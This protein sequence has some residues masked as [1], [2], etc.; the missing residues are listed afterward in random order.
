MKKIKVNLDKKLA[1]SYEICIGRN[2]LDR[3]GLIMA[4]NNWASRYVLIADANVAALHGERVLS[5]LRAAGLKADL[6]DFPP[7]ETA[8]DMETVLRMSRIL[9]ELG[10]DRQCALIA[11]G[12]GVTGDLTG[13]IASIYMRSIPYV[14]IPTSLLAMVDAAIGGKTGIDFASGKNMLGT[15]YQPKAVFVDTGFLATLPEAEFRTGLSEMIKYGIIDDAE[16]FTVLEKEAPSLRTRDSDLLERLV[17]KAG[18]IKK[19]IV[20]IDENERGLRRILNFGH[21]LGHAVE[22]ESGYAVSHGEAVSVGMLGA[23]LLS[24]KMKYLPESDRQRIEALI[25]S[26]GLPTRL[27]RGMRPEGILSRLGMDKKKEGD[28]IH[29]ILI[30]KIGVPFINGGVPRPLIREALEEIGS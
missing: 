26:T 4:K 1:N 16:L 12:G 10:I 9:L 21:T 6:I 24:R 5:G 3:A 13:F 23:A 25:G 8:K 22:A 28:R 11:L 2:I 17:A 20:E 19:G 15:F 18:R 14:Q 27:P 30:K 7:G 29:F